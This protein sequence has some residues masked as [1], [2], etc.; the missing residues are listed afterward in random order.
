[1]SGWKESILNHAWLFIKRVLFNDKSPI[2]SIKA[3]WHLWTI[4]L[5]E[6]VMFIV[7]FF[8]YEQ[9]LLQSRKYSEATKEISR[10]NLY[11]Q[12][13]KS[14]GLDDLDTAIGMGRRLMDLETELSYY[15]DLYS[16][17]H[18]ELAVCR[19]EDGLPPI[20]P[21]RSRHNG[22]THSSES[23]PNPQNPQTSTNDNINRSLRNINRID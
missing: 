9:A 4:L 8:M 1:M 14:H 10:I 11:L 7:L 17:T 19:A 2:E 13:I 22:H 20:A 23:I 12:E 15:K 5:I 16:V 6:V 21:S 3:F 18:G